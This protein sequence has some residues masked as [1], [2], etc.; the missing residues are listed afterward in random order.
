V[1]TLFTYWYRDASNYKANRTVVFAGEY[2]AADLELIASKLA[3]DGVCFIPSQV[4]L[5]DLQHA[6]GAPSDDDHVWHEWGELEYGIEIAD[7]VE[8]TDRPADA[9]VSWAELMQAFR[10]LEDWDIDRAL[11]RNGI[12]HC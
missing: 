11:E 10:E 12:P 9:P 2:T 4:G 6:L 5:V 8:L 1:N 3:E 7:T